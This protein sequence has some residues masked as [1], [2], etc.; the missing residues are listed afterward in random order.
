[1]D[2]RQS[3]A[4]SRRRTGSRS[5]SGAQ[6]RAP[7]QASG[8]PPA[9]AD[10]EPTEDETALNSAAGDTASGVAEPLDPRD[11]RT[12]ER[13]ARRITGGGY[14]IADAALVQSMRAWNARGQ[15]QLARALAERLIDR[16]MPAFKHYAMGLRSRPEDMRDAIS[17][18]IEQLLREAQDP[19]EVFMTQN[20]GY[21]LKCLCVDNFN[22]S[23]RQEGLVTRRDEHGRIT[24]RPRHVPRALIGQINLGA[25]DHDDPTAVGDVVA[26]PHDHH[27]E[28]LAAL[29]AQRILAYLSDPLDRRIMALR[30]FE[31]RQWEDIAALCGKTERTMRLRYEKAKVWLQE[32]LIAEGSIVVDKHVG[33]WIR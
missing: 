5:V 6:T 20:F 15:P 10:V 17:A 11:P 32:C 22:R 12:S 4:S 1:M 8:R 19:S 31:N 16:C 7:A 2:E 3:A 13:M 18:M 30:V 29:E 28:R 21:Y 23:L 26:D 14:E 9:L 25:E 33:E 24:G 27:E